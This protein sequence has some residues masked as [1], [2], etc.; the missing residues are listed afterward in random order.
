MMNAYKVEYLNSTVDERKPIHVYPEFHT[1]QIN[2]YKIWN[3][4]KN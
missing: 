1:Q 4:Y 3:F 2:I